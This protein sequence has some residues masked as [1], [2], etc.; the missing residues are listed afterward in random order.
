MPDDSHRDRL[1]QDIAVHIF[2]VSAGM[3]GVCLTVIG[4]FRLSAKLEALGGIGDDLLAIDALVFLGSC[5]LAYL[6]LRSKLRHRRYCVE[7]AADLLFLGLGFRSEA[8][9]ELLQFLIAR[10]QGLRKIPVLACKIGV[11]AR[12]FEVA[13]AQPVGVLGPGLFFVL[14]LRKLPPQILQ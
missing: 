4:L 14:N 12:Q 13:P 6:A 10:F 11:L 9:V 5:F 1:E 8:G 2:A 3:V 7:Q